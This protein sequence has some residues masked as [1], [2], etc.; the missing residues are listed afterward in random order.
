MAVTIRLEVYGD[1]QLER[2]LERFASAAEDM[3]PAW[4]TLRQ[5]FLEAERRQFAS[6]GGYGSG[7]WPALSP[8]YAAWK[9]R[10]Y[11]GQ[12]ILRRD[13]EL[14]ESLTEGPAVAI[15]EPS[16]MVLGSDVEHGGYHQR[17]DGVPQRRPVELPE[18]ERRE[19]VKVM[20][21]HLIEA[22]QR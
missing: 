15:L 1:V 8:A 17:G 11:P 16:Y 22:G 3:R 20:Q 4:E 14:F 7:G 13:D 9:A 5:R 12:T 19:W 21:R 2:T 18:F 6:Q 10:N